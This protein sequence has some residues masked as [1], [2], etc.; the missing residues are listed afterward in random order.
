MAGPVTAH[1]AVPKPGT[2]YSVQG[3]NTGLPANPQTP[4]HYPVTAHCAGCGEIIRRQAILGA[5][6]E[7][8]HTGRRPGESVE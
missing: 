2:V 8:I 5:A 1:E 7:W 3:S 4:W 6:S